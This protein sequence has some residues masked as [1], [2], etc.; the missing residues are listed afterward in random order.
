[1]S[2]R[3]YLYGSENVVKESLDADSQKATSI[4][5]ADQDRAVV[6]EDLNGGVAVGNIFS[7]RDKIAKAMG[8]APADMVGVHTYG[9]DGVYEVIDLRYLR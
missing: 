9:H 1:M 7:T 2:L 5:S 3:K 4:M 8:I 6:F